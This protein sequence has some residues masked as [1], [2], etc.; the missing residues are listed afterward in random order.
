M[1][2]AITAIVSRTPRCVPS[3]P[4]RTPATGMVPK[5]TSWVVVITRPISRAGT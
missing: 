3:Q 1:T 2:T 4:A 5:L